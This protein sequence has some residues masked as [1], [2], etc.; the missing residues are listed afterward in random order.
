MEEEVK[1]LLHNQKHFERMVGNDDNHNVL[2]I[3]F[4][5]DYYFVQCCNGDLNG[6]Q[7]SK[8]GKS[9]MT[10]PGGMKLPGGNPKAMEAAMQQLQMQGGPG[11][12]QNMFKMFQQMQG[13][14]GS[15]SQQDMLKMFQQMSGKR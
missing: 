14:G 4:A 6:L 9:G 3:P 8:M 1:F 11:A 12:Q 13:G 5:I 7:I 2:I 15:G 10:K